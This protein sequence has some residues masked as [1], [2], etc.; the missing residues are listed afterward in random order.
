MM[1]ILAG[2]LTA[3]R[4]DCAPV[5]G[6][7]MLNRLELST[8]AR[9]RYHK[10]SHNWA[11]IK[12]LLVDLFVEAHERAPRQIILDLDAT[13]DPLHGEGR[14]FHDCYDCYC[15]WPLY[16]FCGRHLLVA[17]PRSA[18][19]DAAA[20]AVEEVAHIAAHIRASGH[21]CAFCCAPTLA[22]RC[23]LHIKPAFVRFVHHCRT[24]CPHARRALSGRRLNGPDGVVAGEADASNTRTAASPLGLWRGCIQSR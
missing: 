4:K 5:A 23:P 19:I 12:T 16:V 1:T 6:K 22:S 2:K 14:F 13:D 8:L 10:I 3:R 11:A 24:A 18:A 15:Y 7:S 9:T 17:R 21:A 20:G